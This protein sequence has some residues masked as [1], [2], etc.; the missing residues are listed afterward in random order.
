MKAAAHTVVGDSKKRH[1]H[2]DFATLAALVAAD[3]FRDA[4]LNKKDRK[5]LRD[6]VAATR[7]DSGVM[8]EL[9]DAAEGLSRLE[10]VARL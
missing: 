7:K 1:H 3:D 6:M 2:L 10:R 8:L 4:V 9:D 5:W